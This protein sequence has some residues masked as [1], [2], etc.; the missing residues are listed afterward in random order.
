MFYLS[1]APLKSVKVQAR[2]FKHVLAWIS[3]K[4]YKL[5]T[6][7]NK[8]AGLW[9]DIA[10]N[11]LAVISCISILSIREYFA[12]NKNLLYCYRSLYFKRRWWPYLTP[13]ASKIAPNF[14]PLLIKI[15]AAAA[16]FFK[17]PITIQPIC[18][19]KLSYFL[20]SRP[21]LTI[22]QSETSLNNYVPKN[23]EF[24]AILSSSTHKNHTSDSKLYPR[25]IPTHDY[26]NKAGLNHNLWGWTNLQMFWLKKWKKVCRVPMDATDQSEAMNPVSF[27]LKGRCGDWGSLVIQIKNTHSMFYFV[28]ENTECCCFSLYFFSFFFKGVLHLLS[29]NQYVLCSISKLPTYFW[30]ITYASDS[31]LA[32]ELKNSIKI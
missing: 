21:K 28:G 30:K 20:S 24:S 11:S 10:C 6:W 25:C 2:K 29:P 26:H 17:Y 4:T 9:L 7:K 14:L 18:F 1:N 3:L 12:I 22:I 31:K 5:K 16:T 23:D 27:D 13:F 8:S 19:D 15:E 32:K